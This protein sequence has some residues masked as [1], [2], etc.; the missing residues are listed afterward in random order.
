MPVSDGLGL[1][2]GGGVAAGRARGRRGLVGRV[3]RVVVAFARGGRHLLFSSWGWGA[4]A[5][6]ACKQALGGGPSARDAARHAD[7]A[8][9]VARDLK[10]GQRGREVVLDT[11]DA[12]EMAR[13]V[14][15]ER[16]VMPHDERV[17]GRLGDVHRALQGAARAGDQLV[18]RLIDDAVLA[19]AAERALEDRVRGAL[20]EVRPLG[21]RPGAGGDLEVLVTRDEEAGPVEGR[22]RVT[23]VGERDQRD[24]GGA[25]PRELR[26]RPRERRR[27]R[28]P[29][30]PRPG[31]RGRRR[32]RRAAR[33]RPGRRRGRRPSARWRGPRCSRARRC[34]R[35]HRSARRRGARAR[36]AG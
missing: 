22:H 10:P 24:G 5:G 16:I 35:A 3:D 33:R 29:R 20:G 36:R 34:R 25:D 9:A 14:L 18:V 21:G 4:G 32:R 7:A 31:W 11:G 26:R 30:R 8:I 23:R 2:A 1:G 15:R 13:R 19:G 17:G 12:I 27:A 28:S 6:V